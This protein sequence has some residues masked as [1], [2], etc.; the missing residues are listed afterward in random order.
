MSCRCLAFFLPALC[1]TGQTFQL[2]P[3]PP[4][5]LELV[6]GQTQVPSGAEQRSALVTLMENT[7][8]NHN[9]HLRGDNPYD[10]QVSFSA[11]ASTLYPAAQGTLEETWLS[12]H[13]W[14]W[15]A[16]LGSY[17]Q[18]QLGSDAAVYG[19]NRAVMPMRL[20]TLRGALFAPVPANGRRLT[21]RTA[22]VSWNGTA[23]T[24]ILTSAGGN[25]QM[26]AQGRQWYENEYCID[27][28]TSTLRVLSIAPGI[29]V[30]YD[31]ANGHKF[32]DH[33]LPGKITV[34]ENGATTVEAQIVSVT[35]ADP[36]NLALYT[37]TAQMLAQGPAPVADLPE[38]FPMIQMSP[39]VAAGS[40]VQPV[41]VHTTMDQSGKILE[42]E[43]LQSNA[44]TARALQEVMQGGFGARPVP[45][46]ASP[47]LREAYINVQFRPMP[48]EQAN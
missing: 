34:T 1:L 31:Y 30:A 5:P 19:Q 8:A 45:A 15:T 41:I 32:H 38:R 44:F 18:L 17:S 36:S 22:A 11:A 27:P 23:L 3:V 7:L 29:Y 6:T 20:K 37:P 28:A 42:I 35:D 39:D 14:R 47:Q 13:D 10:L 24:C 40:V 46:G 43:A 26:P 25:A 4:D 33:L 2:A 9:L 48:S 21:I 12:G 16:S